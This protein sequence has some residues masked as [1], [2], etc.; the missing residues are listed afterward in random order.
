VNSLEGYRQINSNK[1][2][3]IYMKIDWVIDRFFGFR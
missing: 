1:D 2:F 3:W